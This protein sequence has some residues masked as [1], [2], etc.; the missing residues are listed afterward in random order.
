MDFENYQF[1]PIK[2]DSKLRE[3]LAKFEA[4]IAQDFGENVVL[5]AYGKNQD[6][7]NPNS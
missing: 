3:K 1:A 6:S 5:I 4:E 7:T 2:D